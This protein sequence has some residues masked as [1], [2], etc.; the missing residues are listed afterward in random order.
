MYV[1]VQELDQLSGDPQQRS[2]RRSRGV[3]GPFTDLFSVTDAGIIWMP[4]F[5]DVGLQGKP[6]PPTCPV[7][8]A[9]LLNSR[10]VSQQAKLSGRQV[11]V[12]L[13]MEA[14]LFSI[15]IALSEHLV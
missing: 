2:L 4:S 8:W 6:A 7:N 3:L 15:L 1:E 11:D 9:E 14:C 10:L 13:D 12:C 5:S